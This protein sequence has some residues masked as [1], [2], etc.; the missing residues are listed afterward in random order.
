MKTIV[1]HARAGAGSVSV[2]IALTGARA[3]L[4]TIN[5]YASPTP[6]IGE[7]PV[8]SEHHGVVNIS[9]DHDGNGI[10]CQAAGMF[11]PIGNISCALSAGGGPE[12]RSAKITITGTLL[13]DRVMN[14]RIGSGD[15]DALLAFVNEAGF[16][17]K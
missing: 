10:V 7:Q 3:A 8:H 6:E 5:N 13:F 2:T 17:V 14:L 4:I 1:I 15:Y 16:P 11:G 9:R 12:D